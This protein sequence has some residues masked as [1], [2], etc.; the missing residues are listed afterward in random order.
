MEDGSLRALLL[1]GGSPYHN[2]PFHH[3]ELAGILSGEGHMDLRITDHLGVLNR[4][5]LAPLHA[6]INY[7]THLEPTDAQVRA[8]IDAVNHGT[9]F[10]AL[11]GGSA[12]FWNSAPYLEMLGCRFLRHDPLKR[13]T[14][15]IDDDTHPITSG[16]PDF[17]IE[18]E[19]YESAGNTGKF[20]EF[21]S[22]MKSRPLGEYSP[23]GTGPLG[24]DINVLA[25]AE[26]HPLLY[27]KAFGDGRI[28]FNAL[29]HD[30]KALR[31]PHFRRLVIRGTHWVARG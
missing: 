6:I 2:Q 15:H 4:A 10:F 31:N 12:T 11:H 13:F 8:L 1:M 19:L 9:G 28:H 23:L 30:E 25:S 16:I 14:V 5:D 17:D 29:G 27:T 24:D 3:A 7:S 26:G 22:F 18:D 20:A 21:A